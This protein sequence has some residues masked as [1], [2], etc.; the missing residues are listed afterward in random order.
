MHNQLHEAAGPLE[1]LMSK[2]TAV[3]K[4]LVNSDFPDHA[5]TGKLLLW[6]TQKI[7]L[8]PLGKD[9]KSAL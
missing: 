8:T 7:C 6:I 2:K 4:D 3:K 9:L 1:C 5:D